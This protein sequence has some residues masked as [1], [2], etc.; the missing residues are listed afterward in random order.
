MHCDLSLSGVG[1][2]GLGWFDAWGLYYCFVGS[3]LSVGL[4][5]GSILVFIFSGGV[6]LL[7]CMEEWVLM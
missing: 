2:I 6:G 1:W 4:C 3:S 5:E 7:F